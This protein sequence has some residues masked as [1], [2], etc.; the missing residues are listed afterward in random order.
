MSTKST[1]LQRRLLHLCERVHERCRG[2]P[3]ARPQV[4]SHHTVITAG[5]ILRRQRAAASHRPARGHSTSQQALSDHGHHPFGLFCHAFAQ[6]STRNC[7]Q[8]PA[9]SSSFFTVDC[10]ATLTN[11]YQGKYVVNY[12]GFPLLTGSRSFDLCETKK[13]RKTKNFTRSF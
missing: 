3:R 9:V 10:L 12:L 13:K 1:I 6:P 5:W 2:A 8:A 11:I 4:H 7:V